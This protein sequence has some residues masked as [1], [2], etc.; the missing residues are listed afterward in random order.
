LQAENGKS[1]FVAGMYGL[2]STEVMEHV[3]NFHKLYPQTIQVAQPSYYSPMNSIDLLNIAQM[4]HDN[5]AQMPHSDVIPWLTPGDAN[6]IPAEAF[7]WSILESYCNGARGV[8]FWSR[9]CWDGENLLAYSNAIRAIAPAEDII[10]DGQ[11]INNEASA[12]APGHLS[13]MKNGNAMV[14]LISDYMKKSSGT[15]TLNLN[16]SVPSKLIDLQNGKVIEQNLHVG[17]NIVEVNLEENRAR[18]LEVK[19]N[20]LIQ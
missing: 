9:N 14:L 1:T 5:R 11:L 7:K 19:P 3:F 17:K 12:E 18:L 16:I 4:V 8:Y 2:Q 6:P 13:G 15:L 10:M 20:S